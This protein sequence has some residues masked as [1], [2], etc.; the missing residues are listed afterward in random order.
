MILAEERFAI[1]E[2]ARK[3][4]ADGLVVGTSGNISVRSGEL[5]AVTPTGVDYSSL[6]SQD[7]PVVSL[8][9]S[10]VDGD[11]RPTSELPMHLTVYTKAVDP[12][13]TPVNAV[14]HTHSVN[15]TA[16]STLVE[17]VPPIHY[18]LAAIGESAK[19]ARYATYG[20][21]E[22]ADA[23]LE[24]LDN[25]R[26]CLLANHGTITYGDS[27]HSA[28]HR[29]QQLEWVCQVWLT[30]RSAGSPSLLSQQEIE[31][32]VEKLRGYGQR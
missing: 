24:A 11:L 13:G 6:R 27:L 3:M 14:V 7:V 16:V 30:A 23:M 26:G 4:T 17:E 22:L 32:V 29:A 2:Y 9:G 1:C 12:E 18:M 10:I 25:R 19:V 31:H 5:V 28:Y 21:P 8:D 15:A 20:T